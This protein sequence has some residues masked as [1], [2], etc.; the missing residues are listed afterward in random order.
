MK[1][2]NVKHRRARETDLDKL[3]PW[4]EA[5]HFDFGEGFWPQREMICQAIAEG[6]LYVATHRG[7]VV[8]FQLGETQVDLIQ[9]QRRYQLRRIGS[10]LLN[11]VFQ[12]AAKA[13]KSLCFAG[14]LDEGFWIKQGFSEFVGCP[15]GGK[16]LMAL[17]VPTWSRQ[18]ASG[19]GSQAAQPASH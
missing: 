17:H 11:H 1:L 8:G 2:K 15:M 7:K 4:L 14:A 19:C 3:L 13:G 18:L 5:D 6:D 16:I 9:V 10:L 12:R